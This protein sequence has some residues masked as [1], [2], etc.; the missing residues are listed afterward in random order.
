MDWVFYNAAGGTYVIGH[1]GGA[2]MQ[3]SYCTPITWEEA[4]PGDLVFY[5]ENSHVGIV[6]G[7][8]ERGNLLILHCASG[9]NGTVI[10]GAGGF[11]DIGRP[12]FFQ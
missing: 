1:G 5:P 2:T 12:V 11:S 10:T 4:Q 8:D 3:H 9:Y 6:G 7:R